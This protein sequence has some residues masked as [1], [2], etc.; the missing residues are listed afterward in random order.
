MRTLPIRYK[1][2][3]TTTAKDFAKSEA[4]DRAEFNAAME[5]S[6]R[7]LAL[8]HDDADVFLVMANRWA[9]RKA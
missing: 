3:S 2:S 6:C 1:P 8:Y 9:K 4:A 7:L 5:A